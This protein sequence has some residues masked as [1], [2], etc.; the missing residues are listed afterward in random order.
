MIHRSAMQEAVVELEA[1]ACAHEEAPSR[2]QSHST[3]CVQAEVCTMAGTVS[4]T[5]TL[6][7]AGCTGAAGTGKLLPVVAAAASC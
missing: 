4:P 6:L 1:Q 5:V 7:L 2:A 3:C